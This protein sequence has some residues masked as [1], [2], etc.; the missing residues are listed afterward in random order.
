MLSISREFCFLYFLAASKI[1]GRYSLL[2]GFTAFS[3]KLSK[4]C[5]T[6]VPLQVKMIAFFLNVDAAPLRISELEGLVFFIF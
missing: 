4:T 2:N 5:H 3:T 1:N 6:F